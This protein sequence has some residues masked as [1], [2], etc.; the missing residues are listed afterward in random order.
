MKHICFDGER[1]IASDNAVVGFDFRCN[2]A[3]RNCVETIG[4]S[5]QVIW[6]RREAEIGD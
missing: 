2:L 1:A 3:I 4:I 6:I 5:G